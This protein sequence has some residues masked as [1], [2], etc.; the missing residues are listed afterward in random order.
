MKIFY[1][2]DADGKCAGFWVRELA[3]AKELAYAAEYIGYIKM[4]YGREFPFDKIKKNE[5]VYI[6]DYSIEPS[7]MDKLLKITPNVTWIDTIFQ[8][9]KNMKTMTKKFVVSDIME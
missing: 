1:H 5:T 9:L 3:Y 2:N 4:D 8:Q 6:V 7:E